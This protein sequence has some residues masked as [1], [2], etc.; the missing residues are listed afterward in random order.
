MPLARICSAVVLIYNVHFMYRGVFGWGFGMP[1]STA[2]IAEKSFG[3]V[4]PGLFARAFGE[5]TCHGKAG[6][7]ALFVEKGPGAVGPG[8]FTYRK[9]IPMLFARSFD[10]AGSAALYCR[11]ACSPGLLARMGCI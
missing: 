8:V 6:S 7:T 4:G 3:A 11:K 5:E 10:K 9:S 2:L 1:G